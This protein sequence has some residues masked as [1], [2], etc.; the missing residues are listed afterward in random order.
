MSRAARRGALIAVA[1]MA[2]VT[3]AGLLLR[4]LMPI[5]ETRYASVAWEMFTS[6]NWLVPHQNGAPY[7]DKPPLL[8]WLIAAGWTVTGPSSVWLRLVAPLAGLAALL[9]TASLAGR[10]WPAREGPAATAPLITA[11]ALLW[12][13]YASLTLFDSLL[14]CAVLVTLGGLW[15]ARTRPAAWALVA[16]GIAFGLF[17]KGPVILLHVLPVALLAPWWMAADRPVSWTRWYLGLTGAALAGALLVL[18]WAV[19]AA[20]SGGPAYA[21]AIFLRQTA[22]RVVN[23]FAHRRPVWWY[24][25]LI[26]LL[27]FPWVLW[28]RLWRAAAALGRA[29]GPDPGVRFLLAYLAPTLALFS[30]VSGKQMHYLMPL[31]PLAALLAARA[32]DE[33]ADAGAFRPVAAL[34]GGTALLVIALQ[35]GGK[36]PILDGYDLRAAAGIAAAAQ[37]RAAPV[38]WAGRYSGQFGWL[39]RLRRP[40]EIVA[41]SAASA[42]IAAHPDGVLFRQVRGICPAA[43]GERIVYERRLERRTLCGLTA[44]RRGR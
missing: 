9:L 7:S 10:L 17:A 6:G 25:P 37:A 34:A 42:W 27:V 8:F 4:P 43:A 28:P 14:A 24:L 39:G 5:D 30:L 2:A 40:L 16:L 31:V 29:A 32:L 44:M 35:A 23:A 36:R 12:T 19:P 18:A 21:D 11:G 33:A 3:A 15:A 13:V 22:G 38:A 41:D 20:R 1:L 26:P